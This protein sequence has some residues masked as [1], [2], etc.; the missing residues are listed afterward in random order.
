MPVK[1]TLSLVIAQAAL[2]TTQVSA[3]SVPSAPSKAAQTPDKPADLSPA[4]KITNRLANARRTYEAAMDDIREDIDRSFKSAQAN[5]A[6][7]KDAGDQLNQ[8]TAARQ[9]FT[10]DGKVP[11]LASKQETWHRRYAIAAY[12]YVDALNTA[13]AEFNAADLLDLAKSVAHHREQF[14]TANDMNPW[15]ML[16]DGSV[17]GVTNTIEANSHKQ[18]D[19]PTDTEYRVHITARRTGDAGEL[20][21]QLPLPENQF[22]S[23]PAQ[24]RKD[25]TFDIFL[26]VRKDSIGGDAG[27]FWP[28]DY[29]PAT[30]GTKNALF[31]FVTKGPVQ[32]DKIEMKPVLAGSP[33]EKVVPV[34]STPAKRTTTPRRQVTDLRG[35]WSG[36]QYYQRADPTPVEATTRSQDGKRL[37]LK[38]KYGNSVWFWTF[39]IDGTSATLISVDPQNNNQGTISNIGNKSGSMIDGKLSWRGSWDWMPANNSKK[40]RTQPGA[41]LDLTLER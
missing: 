8:L 40:G 31:L 9:A 6:K 25:G 10:Q 30:G 4:Q 19:L 35:N 21:I 13:Q 11:D 36:R 3:A 15:R 28:I 32:I 27:V 20:N 37:E 33:P 14:T 18:F 41:G 34:V 24:A 7:K 38:V 26:T 23:L 12:A 29:Q 2:L 17:T 5:A 16:F 22:I 39:K 1:F